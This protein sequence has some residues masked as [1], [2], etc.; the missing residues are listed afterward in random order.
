M[1]EASQKQLETNKSF[2]TAV[3]KKY[4]QEETRN[5]IKSIVRIECD[6]EM[7]FK[8]LGENIFPRFINGNK[9]EREKAR[10]DFDKKTMAAI[11]ALGLE[12]Y[13]PLA[14]TVADCYRPLIIESARQIEK[15]Y[16]CKAPSERMLAGIIANAFVRVIDNSRRLDN[17][18][19]D[20]GQSITENKTKYLTMLSKQVDRANRQFLNALM[21]LKQLKAPAI[22]MHIKAKNAFVSQNQQI[23][24][25]KENNEIVEPK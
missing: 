4:T 2:G 6:P 16:K 12:N 14:E 11:F 19:G 8:T 18:L 25:T 24:V 7:L 22:E 21:T 9:E 17:E 13:Y 5:L 3:I 10:G 1:S 20:A 15:E 23:N